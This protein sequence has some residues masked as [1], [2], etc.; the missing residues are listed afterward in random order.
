M[1]ERTGKDDIELR[2]E[3]VQEILTRPPG[4]LVRWGITMFF[5]VL[6]V[7]LIGGCFFTYPDTVSAEVTVT[8][9][10]PPVWMVA[11]VSGK[12]KEL[13]GADRDSVHP[14]DW[15]AVLDN[16]AETKDVQRV[17]EALQGFVLTDSCVL[18]AVFPEKPALGSIQSAYAAFLRGL[19]DYRNFLSLDL[20]AQQLEATRRELVEYRHY[21]AHLEKQ[22]ELDK[23]QAA[24]AENMHRREKTLYAEG[25]IS[26]E[27]YEE[28]QQGLLSKRQ[29]T[30]QLMTSLSSAR[31]QEAQLRQTLVETEMER[32]R[33][34][35][36]LRTAL[37]TAYNDLLTG[38][39]DWGLNYLFVSPAD[40]ILSYNEVWE[41]NQYVNG[42]DKVFS[43]VAEHPGKVIGKMLLPAEGSGKVKPGQRVN[44]SLT[45]YPY[46]EF[47]FLTGQVRTVSLLPDEENLYT[48]T[49]DLPQD[50]HTSYG[51]AVAFG[52][53]MPGVAE[54][55]SDERSVTERLVSPLRYLWEKYR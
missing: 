37:K 54:V 36:T 16:P 44:I 26:E 43:V 25:L 13:Y 46:L 45:G 32:A 47:G 11:R 53:E 15:I 5:G 51:Y 55:L 29:G 24:I 2:S 4:A 34:E 42:G 21:I 18:A 22:V 19:T 49:V 28:A 50:L 6:A 1:P 35:N 31:I 12:I 3:E 10:R 48:V 9:E 40:G 38:I 17:Q 39:E 30:E 14:G 41:K 33:E 8:T 52:G 20:Y 23:Q 27:E 7:L